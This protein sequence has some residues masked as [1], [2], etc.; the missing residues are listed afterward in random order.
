MNSLNRVWNSTP[1]PP[2]LYFLIAITVICSKTVVNKLSKDKPYMHSMKWAVIMSLHATRVY[3]PNVSIQTYETWI[4]WP[5][6][7][8]HSGWISKL[9]KHQLLYQ[10]LEIY[11]ILKNL[12]WLPVTSSSWWFDTMEE[13]QQESHLVLDMHKEWDFQG[14]SGKSSWRDVL[15]HKVTTLKKIFAWHCTGTLTY[16]AFVLGGLIVWPQNPSLKAISAYPSWV[17]HL[18]NF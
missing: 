11:N 2:T 15:L 16:L 14:K 18:R 6:P 3:M 4:F 9:S 10:P 12:I 1:P 7:C 8:A 5:Y 17:Y 13:I